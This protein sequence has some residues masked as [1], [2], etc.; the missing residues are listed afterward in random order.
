VYTPK[1]K[2]ERTGK[3]LKLA[4]AVAESKGNVEGSVTEVLAAYWDV[5]Q[6]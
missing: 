5:P 4:F 6:S 2:E 1:E 3:S